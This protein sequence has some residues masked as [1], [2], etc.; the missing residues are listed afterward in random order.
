MNYWSAPY[1]RSREHAE[2]IRMMLRGVALTPAE[3]KGI[4]AFPQKP[5]SIEDFNVSFRVAEMHTD[6]RALDPDSWHAQD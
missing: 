5:P 1:P 6:P 3:A 4:S 2:A